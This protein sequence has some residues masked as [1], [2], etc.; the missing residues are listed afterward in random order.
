MLM[1]KK[2]FRHFLKWLQRFS[3]WLFLGIAIVSGLVCVLS[4]RNNN[5]TVLKLRDQVLAADKDNGDVESAL[6]KLRQYMYAHMNTSLTTGPNAIKP[7]IQLKYRYERLV[8]A[9][10]AQAGANNTKIYTDAQVDC[11]KRFPKGLYG[12]NRIPC[13]QEYITAHG[14]TA[15]VLQVE[16]SLYKFDFVSPTW[17]PDLAGWMLV[18][19]SLSFGLF[20]IRIGLER[21]ARA[22]LT[23]L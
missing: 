4:L 10:L 19:S 5:L 12:S 15:P 13:I 2:F 11:E 3:P 16:D 18:I 21:W 23:D 20:V 8:S 17:S 6:R 22:E 7:P 1:D 14:I 9:Q